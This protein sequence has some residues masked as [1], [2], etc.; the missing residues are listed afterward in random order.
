MSLEDIKNTLS[1]GS[2]NDRYYSAFSGYE[3]IQ[4]VGVE[5]DFVFTCLF[6]CPERGY[7]FTAVK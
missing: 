7:Y 3:I 6:W 2:Y 4:L 5:V 1:R